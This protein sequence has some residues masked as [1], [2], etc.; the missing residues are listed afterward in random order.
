MSKKSDKQK[1]KKYLTHVI[2]KQVCAG[3]RVAEDMVP[4]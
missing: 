3:Y 1:K 4:F 2:Q